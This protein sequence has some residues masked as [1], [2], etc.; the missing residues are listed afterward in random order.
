MIKLIYFKKGSAIAFVLVFATVLLVMGGAYVKMTANT[1]KQT[2]QIDERVKLDY[3]A[4][5]MT[6]LAL[7]KF[8]LYPADFYA[9]LDAFKKNPNFKK[10]YGGV[11]LTPLER[12]SIGDSAFH[13][14]ET[15]SKSTYNQTDVKLE[16]ASMTILSDAKWNNE[17]LR[18]IAI[19]EY[20][21]Q[22]QRPV[23]KTA[24]RTVNI[25]RRS[26]MP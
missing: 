6:E 22:F 21:D 3:L 1:K 13:R 14:T 4:N 20:K 16:I 24:V 23:N 7:L 25:K 15:N 9:C 2:V 18:I 12:F 17:I 26:Q 11:E 19:A 10:K 5:S 8:Q